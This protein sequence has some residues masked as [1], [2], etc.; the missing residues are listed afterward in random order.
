MQM[1]MAASRPLTAG[2]TRAFGAR[3]ASGGRMV[4]QAVSLDTVQKARG[5]LTSLIKETNCA[6]ILIRLAWHDSGTFSKVSQR[7]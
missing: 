2:P 5:Q 6:P 4:V 7:K 1:Q 3:R